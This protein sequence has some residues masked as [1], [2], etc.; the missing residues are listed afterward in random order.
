MKTAQNMTDLN[1]PFDRVIW[2]AEQCAQYLSQSYSQ[3]MKRTQFET[4][5]PPRCPLP[6]QPR[7]RAQAV[8]DWAIGQPETGTNLATAT[9][10]TRKKL[11]TDYERP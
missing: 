6:G 4:G 2:T 11:R 8:A 9:R 7:W 10:G 1:V 3:F 5:F